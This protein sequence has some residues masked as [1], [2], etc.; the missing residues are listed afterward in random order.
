MHPETTEK[1]I[2]KEIIPIWK[3]KQLIR[4]LDIPTLV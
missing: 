1:E 4:S 3:I 2:E